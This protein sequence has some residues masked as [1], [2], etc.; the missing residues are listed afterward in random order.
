MLKT[1]LGILFTDIPQTEEPLQIIHIVSRVNEHGEMLQELIL[2]E[3]NLSKI[4][5]QDSVKDNV[6][7]IVSIAGALRKGKSFLLGFFLKYL[8]AEV[9][10]YKI[11]KMR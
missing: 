8:E 4:M 2:N 5:E 1:I 3:E 7:M 9:N 10:T 6:V 11:F